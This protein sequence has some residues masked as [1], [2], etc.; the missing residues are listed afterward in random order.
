MKALKSLFLIICL[1]S[2]SNIAAQQLT[3]KQKKLDEN[4]VDYYSS[5]ERDNLQMWFHDRVAGMELTSVQENEYFSVV[6]YYVFK[7]GRLNDKDNDLSKEKIVEKFFEYTDKMNDEIKPILNEEQYQIH[8]E[9]FETLIKN[10]TKRLY[11]E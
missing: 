9:S 1:I 3:E 10:T 4:K 7:L 8:I 11:Q 2:F 6:V 5:E